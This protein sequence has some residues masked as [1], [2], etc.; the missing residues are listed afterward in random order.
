MVFVYYYCRVF[1]NIDDDGSKSLDFSEFKKGLKDVG[2]SVSDA[3]SA[4]CLVE[5]GDGTVTVQCM[6]ATFT[7]SLQDAR[8]M[9]Q[10][11]DKDGN[12]TISFDEF[13]MALRVSVGKHLYISPCV[14]GLTHLA[15]WL[16]VCVRLCSLQ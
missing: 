9:F 10:Q 12:G 16:L 1:R 8:A 4:E 14:G 3:V 11:F 2:L 5:G 7:H 6:H 13:L 15:T